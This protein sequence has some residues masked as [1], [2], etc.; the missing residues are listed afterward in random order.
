MILYVGLAM[1]SLGLLITFLGLGE[2]TSG[3]KTMEMKLIGPS[4]VGCGVFFAVLRILFCTVRV[5]IS[6]DSLTSKYFSSK[7][8]LRFPRAVGR[9]LDAVVAALPTSKSWWR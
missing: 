5:I 9:Y 2:G 8:P 4:L 6:E 3:F 7:M 1:I